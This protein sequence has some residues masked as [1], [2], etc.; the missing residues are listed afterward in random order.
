VL[1]DI[2]ETSGLG[3]GSADALPLRQANE[4]AAKTI[5]KA[6]GSAKRRHTRAFIDMSFFNERLLTGSFY[7]G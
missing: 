7:S 6:I 5:A 4:N 3:D 2:C 1:G